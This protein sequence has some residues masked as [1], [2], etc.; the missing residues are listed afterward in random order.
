MQRGETPS[1][2][3]V[4]AAPTREP[5]KPTDEPTETPTPE[6]TATQP[7][8]PTPFPTV[9]PIEHKDGV[10]KFN[11]RPAMLESPMPATIGDLQPAA[12][13]LAAPL[14]NVPR[15]VVRGLEPGDYELQIDDDSTT[16]RTYTHKQLADGV[17]PIASP[18]R[19]GNLLP[20]IRAKNELY[21]HRWRPQNETYLLLFRKHEQGNNAVEIPMFDPLVADVESEIAELRRASSIRFTITKK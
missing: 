12:A 4:A 15:L 1:T 3:V 10:L 16:T 6:P 9:T 11:V 19:G 5:A 13:A 21:F 20:R 17:E 18:L 8:T 2:N 7:P 14:L